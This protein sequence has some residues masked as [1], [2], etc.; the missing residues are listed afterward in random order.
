MEEER[1]LM[2]LPF[3]QYQ[4]Y[5]SVRR[6]ADLIS[7]GNR[8]NVLDVGGWPGLIHEFLGSYKTVVVDAVETDIRDYIRADGALLP[9]FAHSFEMVACLDVLE[10]V[11]PDRRADFI[12]ELCR[13]SDGCIVM[14]AP[15]AGDYV[16]M[17]EQLLYDYVSRVFGEFPTLREHLE[18]GLP[19]LSATERIFSEIGYVVRS[20]PSGNIFNWLIM[21]FIKHYVM[22]VLDEQKIQEEIDE[23]YNMNF[24]ANDFGEP[25]YRHIL[26]AVKPELAGLFEETDALFKPA[27]EITSMGLSY[28][29]QSFSMLIDLLD[30]QVAHQF[31]DFEARFRRMEDELENKVGDLHRYQR[32][33]TDLETRLA[34]VTIE[35]E[36]AKR[37]IKLDADH[38]ANLEEFVA[39]V[40]NLAVYR[41]YRRMVR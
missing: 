1:R 34:D 32:Q 28:R 39:K 15:F 36:Q 20:Y 18:Y 38:I 40:K 4:R 33:I 29:L 6:V 22:A 5:Q 30:L 14:T 37:K 16:T 7:D 11:E 25:S 19:Q 35:L 26:I 21:M 8:I 17:A 12:S 2:R 24:S 27:E 3:D 10:H 23:L 41:L 13:V 31:T 9:F